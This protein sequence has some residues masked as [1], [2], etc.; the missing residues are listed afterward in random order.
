[1]FHPDWAT[2]WQGVQVTVVGMGL[3]FLALG[4]VIL[5]MVALTRL[6]WLQPREEK[7][8]AEGAAEGG[9]ETAEVHQSTEGRFYFPATEERARVA[10]AV[11]VAHVARAGG[12][13]TPAPAEGYRVARTEWFSA[14]RTYGRIRQLGE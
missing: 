7:A 6:P 14:W 10:A 12:R 11:A 13:V 1:M 3:V 5:A 8:G 2:V 4:L 9:G